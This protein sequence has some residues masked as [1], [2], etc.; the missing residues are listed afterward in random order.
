MNPKTIQLLAVVAT[1]LVVATGVSRLMR[2]PPP[3]QPAVKTK[4]VASNTGKQAEPPCTIRRAPFGGTQASLVKAMKGKVAHYIVLDHP[5]D[6]PMAPFHQH[7][8]LQANYGAVQPV[9][10]GQ[11]ATVEAAVMRAASLCKRN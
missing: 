1:C 5:Q 6:N 8:W 3:E 9:V 7:D 11:F 2:P 4:S 10:M